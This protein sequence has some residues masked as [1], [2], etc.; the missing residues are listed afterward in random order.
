MKNYIAVDPKDVRVGDEVQLTGYAKILFPIKLPSG[1]AEFGKGCTGLF[2]RV[3][4]V[5]GYEDVIRVSHLSDKNESRWE[6]YKQNI[7]SARRL[8]DRRSGHD[9]RVVG[10]VK[11]G[12]ENT[13]STPAAVRALDILDAA[14]MGGNSGH[15]NDARIALVQ[16]ARANGKSLSIRNSNGRRSTD[17]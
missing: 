10:T 16:Q 11:I 8:Q 12:W 1:P 6:I 3:I 2:Y 5:V 4:S 13:K 15:T 9:R 14:G 7:V 17:K